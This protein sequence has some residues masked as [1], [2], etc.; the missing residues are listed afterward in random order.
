MV[1]SSRPTSGGPDTPE[2]YLT[3]TELAAR[4][5]LAAK[6]VRNRMH[7]GT[8]RR[9]VHWLSPHGISPRFRWSAILRWL[10]GADGI[11]GGFGA[12]FGPDIPPP[13]RRARRRIDQRPG[14]DL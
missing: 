3:V 14:R 2:E 11:A 5:K 10:E 9:G 4:L 13:R 7:D 6:T 12:A 8:W 1:G